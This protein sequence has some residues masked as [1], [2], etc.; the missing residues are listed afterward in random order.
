MCHAHALT[1]ASAAILLSASCDRRRVFVCLR[2]KKI[3]AI[4]PDVQARSGPL[5]AAKFAINASLGHRA[6]GV[7]D[8]SCACSPL[9]N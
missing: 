7:R 9:L 1:L 8:S 5:G 4:Q 6:A 3:S 2:R